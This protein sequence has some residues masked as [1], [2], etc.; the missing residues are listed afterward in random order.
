MIFGN[1]SQKTPLIFS[2]RLMIKIPVAS[3]KSFLPGLVF[4]L[5]RLKEKKRK[6]GEK[7]FVAC[8]ADS[9]M[10]RPNFVSKL[11]QSLFLRLPNEFS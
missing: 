2:V 8:G 9:A 5:P 3:K 6:A 1:A 7:S 11:I 10:T 4:L